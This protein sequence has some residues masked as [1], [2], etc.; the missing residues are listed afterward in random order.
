MSKVAFEICDV[1]R[2]SQ[3]SYRMSKEDMLDYFSDHDIVLNPDIAERIFND[4]EG[5]ICA[6]HLTCRI[7]EQE[8]DLQLYA[9]DAIRSNAMKAIESGIISAMDTD[10]QR[11]LV[12]ISLL[13]HPATSL[14]TRISEPE[15][16]QKLERLGGENGENAFIRYDELLDSY[17]IHPLLL[18][19]LKNR[20]DMLE[21]HE[22]KAVLIAAAG[23]SVE[24]EYTLDA[25]RYY[26]RLGDYEA[27]IN[28]AFNL[29]LV[30][31]TF[32]MEAMLDILERMPMHILEQDDRG[33][34]LRSR[35]LMNLGRM[36]EATAFIIQKLGA[37]EKQ[38]ST[39]YKNR[40]MLGL[41]N[42]MGYISMI[43]SLY[44]GQ[45]DFASHFKMAAAYFQKCNFT[46]ERTLVSFSLGPFVNR[47]GSRH[48][49]EFNKYIAA[50]KNSVPYVA[51]YSNGT[52]SGLHELAICE[53]AY[54][55]GDMDTCERFA[56][57]S[58]NNA[59]IHMQYEIENRALFFLLRRSLCSGNVEDIRQIYERI[60]LQPV[61]S[62]YPERYRMMDI[63]TSWLFA[64]LSLSE[65]V[66]H[67][68][69]RGVDDKDTNF[70]RKGLGVFTRVKYLLLD[71]QYQQ[72]LVMLEGQKNDKDLSAFLLGQIG[73]YLN[74]AFCYYHLKDKK[75][76]VKAFEEAYRLARPN[77][78]ITI[79]IEAGNNMR[80]LCSFALKYEHCMI[81]DDWLKMIN[82]KASTYA[83]RLTQV[84][85]L[86]EDRA[87]KQPGALTKTEY[88]VLTKLSK[89]M[90]R[91]DI[92]EESNISINTVKTIIGDAINKLGAHNA[93]EAVSIALTKGLIR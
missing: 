61:N 39:E 22:T 89:G 78:L 2:T 50:L 85:V 11:F 87:I 70:T 9:L 35:L 69:R 3:D 48:K 58:V 18:S 30:T 34:I 55:T 62:E 41:Y 66:A 56:Y 60:K 21:T 82:A 54:Y 29:N 47:V 36:D 84:E 43:Q 12:K 45:Y 68:I 4:T 64:Q 76:A 24:H 59:Q 81:P 20:Q 72:L 93:T 63:I 42:N 46:G 67:W 16:L 23:W 37:L 40:L 7:F 91:R 49:N 92:A 83:K 1:F 17:H 15:V 19:V 57:R 88:A 90:S 74:L 32:T 38:P 52:M 79:F 51:H 6:V 33:Y 53:Y 31:S 80:S 14:L 13:S 73:I 71:A 8:P 5:W 77:S 75:S 86:F 44:S 26:D 28:I 25:L 27:F 10:L 65:H